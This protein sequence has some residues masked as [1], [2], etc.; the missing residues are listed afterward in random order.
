M[1]AVME[2]FDAIKIVIPHAIALI[3][4]NVPNVQKTHKNLQDV[5]KKEFIPSKVRMIEINI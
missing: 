3:K 2:Q 4:D 1:K 5:P